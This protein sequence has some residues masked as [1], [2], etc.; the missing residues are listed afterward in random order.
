MP[1]NEKPENL[2]P[3]YIKSDFKM[4]KSECLIIYECNLKKRGICKHYESC[5]ESLT[6]IHSDGI[7]CFSIPAIIEIL[8][9]ESKLL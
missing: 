3:P 2:K 9:I 6:C 1:I 4:K 8:T 5:I 7:H